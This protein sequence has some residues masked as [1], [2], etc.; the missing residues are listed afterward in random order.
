MQLGPL[1]ITNS[2]KLM[3]ALITPVN[4]ND[5]STSHHCWVQIGNLIL[6]KE[7]ALRERSTHLLSIPEEEDDSLC[8]SCKQ[9]RELLKE[10]EGD[11]AW[12]GHVVLYTICGPS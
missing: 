4:Y 10:V 2:I 6:C 11:A 8:S 3:L 1:K 7:R 9:D 5:D 12:A